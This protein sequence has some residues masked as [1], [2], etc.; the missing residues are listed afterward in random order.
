MTPPNKNNYE[1][2]ENVCEFNIK[3]HLTW[4]PT[5][6]VIMTLSH[7]YYMISCV[8]YRIQGVND[9]YGNHRIFAL[10][11]SRRIW[12]R[13]QTTKEISEHRWSQRSRDIKTLADWSR[14]GYHWWCHAS[15]Y[16]YPTIKPDTPGATPVTVNGN[17]AELWQIEAEMD[18][19]MDK[20][21]LF[22]PKSISK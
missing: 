3:C 5:A 15:N 12:G 8:Y 20:C 7:I 11:T 6:G 4:V 16:F 18:C 19:W 1:M 2:I 22:V 9:E 13:S 14:P 21:T 10:Y 17:F